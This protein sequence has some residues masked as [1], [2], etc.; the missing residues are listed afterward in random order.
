[1]VYRPVRYFSI[2]YSF[3]W[4]STINIIFT[5]GVFRLALFSVR[6][7]ITIMASILILNIARLLLFQFKH[8]LL[9]I[10]SSGWVF[11]IVSSSSIGWHVV[12]IIGFTRRYVTVL[13][14]IPGV[15][16][17]VDTWLHISPL[18]STDI[19]G[20]T[21]SLINWRMA[22]WINLLHLLYL[23]GQVADIVRCEWDL[24][25]AD[26]EELMHNCN[27][28]STPHPNLYI[29]CYIKFVLGIIQ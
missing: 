2:S 6:C 17:C 24:N 3:L 4:C 13:Y 12:L 16:W 7:A 14:I 23:T 21:S 5:S 29:F 19:F 26:N 18:A 8:F 10:S 25:L 28:R 9:F 20:H 22:L 11:V 15:T 1:M 27:V